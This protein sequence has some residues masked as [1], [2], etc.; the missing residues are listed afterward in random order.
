[1]FSPIEMPSSF[2]VVATMP[3]VAPQPGLRLIA[4]GGPCVTSGFGHLP[5]IER[6]KRLQRIEIVVLGNPGTPYRI[7]TSD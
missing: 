7:R 1:M 2:A 4:E 3:N 6:Q 5:G